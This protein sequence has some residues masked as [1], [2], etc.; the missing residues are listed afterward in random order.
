MSVSPLLE[1]LCACFKANLPKQKID[2]YKKSERT[3]PDG[4]KI[5]VMPDGSVADFVPEVLDPEL[6]TEQKR[7]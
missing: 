7:N 5:V 3:G 2:C 1:L 4:E 6:I